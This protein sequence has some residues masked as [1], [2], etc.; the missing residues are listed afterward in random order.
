MINNSPDI[1]EK[2]TFKLID[3][4][5]LKNVDWLQN[6][7]TTLLLTEPKLSNLVQSVKATSSASAI[8]NFFDKERDWSSERVHCIADKLMSADR[9]DYQDYTLLTFMN[10]GLTIE[11]SI[12]ALDETKYAFNGRSKVNIDYLPN[13]FHLNAQL[14]R[15]PLCEGESRASSSGT[16]NSRFLTPFNASKTRKPKSM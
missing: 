4:L 11:L 5:Q 2:I 16:S 9:S 7:V 3:S 10:A 1:Y 14:R 6:E 13:I 12:Y 15:K 8:D